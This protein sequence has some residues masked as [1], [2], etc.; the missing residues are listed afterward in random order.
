MLMQKRGTAGKL[1][2][3]YAIPFSLGDISFLSPL[4]YIPSF[5]LSPYADFSWAGGKD[6]LVSVGAELSARF[7]NFLFVPFGGSF[8]ISVEWNGGTLFDEVR[9]QTGQSRITA[10]LSYSMDF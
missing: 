7:S 1:T 5:A 2:A 10:G 9:D 8:G 6:C 3:D 4:I